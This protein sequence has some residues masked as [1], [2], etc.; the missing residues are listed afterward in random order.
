MQREMVICSYGRISGQ[1]RARRRLSSVCSRWQK[2]AMARVG[3]RLVRAVIFDKASSERD[4]TGVVEDGT[5]KGVKKLARLARRRGG[6]QPEELRARQ[7]ERSVNR[8]FTVSMMSST[9]PAA[10]KALPFSRA[11]AAPLSLIPLR[12]REWTDGL[13]CPDL[14]VVGVWSVRARSVHV[15]LMGRTGRGSEN[16]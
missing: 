13:R 10:V 11:T 5:R 12:L 16:R 2:K 3:G 7:G 9:R 4:W 6:G 15:G 8:M 1:S 14:I